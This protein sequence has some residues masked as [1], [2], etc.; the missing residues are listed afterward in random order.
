MKN[1]R[2]KTEL[3]EESLIESSALKLKK[4][5]LLFQPSKK[6]KLNYIGFFVVYF[7]L[8][9][10][11]TYLV[12]YIPV[13]L[14]NILNVNRSDLAFIQVFT[15]SVLLLA[16][17]LGFFFD[18]YNR[19][20]KKILFLSILVCILSFICTIFS[21]VF[22]YLFGSFL[23]L[24]LLSSEIIKVCMSR[25]ILESSLNEVIKDRNLTIINI[26]ANFGGFISSIIFI[27]LVND[28]YNLE[29]WVYFFL[30][31][32][33]VIL[34]ILTALF[35]FDFKNTPYKHT[36]TRKTKDNSNKTHH[37]QKLLLTLSYILIWSDRL[38]QYPLVSW[39]TSKYG[40]IGL[41]IFSFSYVFFLL[42]NT[43]GWMI[44]QKISN[45]SKRNIKKKV[46]NL[47]PDFNKQLDLDFIANKRIYTIIITNC[48][49]I[50][51][52]FLMI[53]S[54]LIILLF[55]YSLIWF[56]A[57]IMMLNY[58]SLSISI[59][60]N[61]KYQTFSFQIFK[62]G[63]A[64]ASVIFIPMGTF[65]SS[66]VSTESLILMVGFLS[67]FSLIPLFYLK[68]SYK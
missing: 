33:I 5:I 4:E 54:N 58:I 43:L 28:I 51:L 30:F 56:V 31:G 15:F 37:F 7:T 36:H 39:I 22:L 27:I 67:F 17:A 52:T 26:S 23:A 35:C 47:N 59:S 66:F 61:M 2:F 44:G 1:S 14:L 38:Y 3:L 48:I 29:L 12:V 68:H 20:R 49:Y 9:I 32:G 21:G 45:N 16:P 25:I 8:S 11:N 19:Q 6:I 63:L 42:L 24:N 62:L 65:L 60:K 10:I 41:K 18:K 64:V 50:L 53:F 57:G 34:P 55:I 46:I 13:Y 40:Q